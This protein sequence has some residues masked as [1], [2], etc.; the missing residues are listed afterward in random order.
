[1][2]SRSNSI[3]RSQYQIAA[4]TPSMNL[5]GFFITCV[6][7]KTRLCHITETGLA[8][9]TS[10]FATMLFGLAATWSYS[11]QLHSKDYEIRTDST[12]DSAHLQIPF[13]VIMFRLING[14]LLVQRVALE[15]TRFPSTLPSKSVSTAALTS[16]TLRKSFRSINLM[17]ALGFT[18]QTVANSSKE[19]RR[20]SQNFPFSALI[21]VPGSSSIK[22]SLNH[23]F[24]SE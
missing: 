5:T 13:S 12:I 18:L 8:V 23:V 7:E 1:M 4:G 10:A 22:T 16:L 9:L 2:S 21:S 14:Y 3:T 17:V 15:T 19:D 24:L 20:A 11:R 6:A